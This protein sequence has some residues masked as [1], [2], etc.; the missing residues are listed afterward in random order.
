MNKRKTK[1]KKMVEN[2]NFNQKKKYQN[3]RNNWNLKVNWITAIN[4][5]IRK[6]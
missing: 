1:K 4:S 6:K 3:L 2:Y 5:M